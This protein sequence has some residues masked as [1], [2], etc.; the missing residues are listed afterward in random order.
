MSRTEVVAARPD[1][2]Y[3]VVRPRG[4]ENMLDS[5]HDR[6]DDALEL[7]FAGASDAEVKNALSANP[8]TLINNRM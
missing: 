3:T 8:Q 2:R 7:W 4:G 1:S 6:M 5:W